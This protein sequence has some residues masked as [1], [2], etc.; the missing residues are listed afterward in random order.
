MNFKVEANHQYIEEVGPDTQEQ[1][2]WPGHLVL[3]LVGCPYAGITFFYDAVSF[4]EVP[5]SDCPVKLQ[6]NYTLLNVPTELQYEKE[7][8]ERFLFLVLVELIDQ[9]VK[10]GQAIYANGV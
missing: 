2:A 6:W 4:V 1:L 5:H 3:R 10:S 8:L 7:D 9:K